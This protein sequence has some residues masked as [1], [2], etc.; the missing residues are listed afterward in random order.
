MSLRVKR[1]VDYIE[2]ETDEIKRQRNYDK[3]D[4]KI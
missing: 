3:D 2:K 4:S 1:H